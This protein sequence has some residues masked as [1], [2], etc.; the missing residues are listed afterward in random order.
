MTTAMHLAFSYSS[1]KSCGDILAAKANE[2][3]SVRLLAASGLLLCVAG[4]W[5]QSRDA[6]PPAQSKGIDSALLAKAK[7]GD[8]DAEFRIAVSY[9]DL[10]NQKESCRWFR[11]AAEN[12]NGVAQA[13][14]G[15]SYESGSAICGIS[16]DYPQAAFWF[17][18]AANQG[19]AG[20]Q[21]ALGSLYE[22]GQGVPQ[23]YAQAA[24]WYRKAAEHGLADAQYDLGDFYLFGHGVPVDYA[25]GIM[26][27]R[28]AA[29][30]GHPSAQTDLAHSYLTGKFVPQDYAL[31]ASWYRKA[32]E[33]GNPDGQAGLA[34]MYEDGQGLPKSYSEAY[35]WISLAAANPELAG[36]YSYLSEEHAKHRDRIASHLTQAELLNVQGRTRAWFAA[37]PPK[38]Q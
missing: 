16:R 17:R 30:Q 19:E 25:Q 23:D 35:F 21:F 38:A 31:A 37:H 4:A 20:A 15:D 2:M 5:A 14:L 12:G 1:P 3:R 22:N 26:W 27:L 29:E 6:A 7:A 28:M 9:S 10:G 36:V 24:I 13:G 34:S 33:R 18:K 11:M 8:A 32:A